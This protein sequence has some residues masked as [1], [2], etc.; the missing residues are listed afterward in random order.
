[1]TNSKKAYIYALVTVLFWST[2]ATAFKIALAHLDIFQLLF[3]ACLTSATILLLPILYNRQVKLLIE[4]GR[5]HWKRSLLFASLNPL[6]YYIILLGAY[7]RLPAQIVQPINYTWA[8]VLTF[9]SVI[10][11]KQKPIATDYAGALVCYIGVVLISQGGG[12]AFVSSQ[13]IGICLAIFSTLIWASYWILNVNDPRDQR[14]AMSLNFL[15][16]LPIAALICFVMSSF[17]VEAKGLASAIYIG[18]FEMGLA[19][20]FWS[21]A[22][23]M[24]E[25]TSRVST[26]VFLAPFIS[27]IFIQQILNE[28][29]ESST[30]FGLLVIIL[31]L[32]IQRMGVSRLK[33]ALEQ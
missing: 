10:F 11:L 24:A 18:I 4:E 32:V 6:G 22:L 21:K 5:I 20:L 7:D 26:L 27:L 28:T 8:I 33:A 9:M 19:F 15:F 17:L 30:Y 14:V 13:V 2:V 29:I 25:N 23:R 16:A 3:Y 12:S 1:M 31:G